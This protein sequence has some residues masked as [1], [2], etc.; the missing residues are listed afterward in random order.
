MPSSLKKGKI[1]YDI[2]LA[3]NKIYRYSSLIMKYC[4]ILDDD[5]KK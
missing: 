3:T 2:Y 5:L 1:Y 4:K